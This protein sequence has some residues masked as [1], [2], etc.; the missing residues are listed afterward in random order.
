MIPLFDAIPF[1]WMHPVF[2]HVP[3]KAA[4]LREPA[5]IKCSSSRSE[6]CAQMPLTPVTGSAKRFA[7]VGNAGTNR[8]DETL[9]PHITMYE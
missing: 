8:R 1:E 5:L 7:P 4:N 2:A 6:I 3:R 9:R